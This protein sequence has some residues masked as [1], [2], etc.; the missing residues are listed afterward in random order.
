MA[1]HRLRQAVDDRADASLPSR[2]GDFRISVFRVGGSETEVVAM[3]HGEVDGRAPVLVRLHSECLTGEALGSL[4]CDCGDQLSRA[5]EQIGRADRG[6]LLYLRHEGRGIGLFDKIRAYALQ[7]GGLDTVDAN[8]AL[9]LPIDARDYAA[10]VSVLRSLGVQRVRVLTN[11]PAKLSALQRHGV[12]VVERVALET[13]AN[14]VSL[15]YL[16]TKRERMGHLLERVDPGPARTGAARP[17]IT[18]HWAQTLD[19]R[20]AT[21]TGDARWVS[22]EQSLHYAHRLRAAND[23]VLVG[24]GTVLADDPQLTVRSVPGR[25]P[26][27]VIVDS[28]LRIPT[29]ARALDGRAPAIVLTTAAA[30][31]ADR[32]RVRSMGAEVIVAE[33]DGKVVDLRDGVRR[34]ARAGVSSL[35]VEGGR[36]ILTSLLRHRLVDRLTVCIAPKVLGQGIEAVGDLEISRL[37][38][39]LVFSTSR[40]V[41]CGEDIVFEGE[42]D[43]AHVSLLRSA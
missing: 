2:F 27:R 38:D 30:S 20:I 18:I 43:A 23:A 39:A 37:R 29:D 32:D 17:R 19:G 24:V 6:V 11:N 4:R 25:S 22:G 3:V 13:D 33:R 8:V 40:F 34:L 42:L 14:A 26:V 41:P 7:D 36:G 28:T 9:G 31:D 10:A 15:P 12:E 16:R 1:I 35:L 5:L 21:R